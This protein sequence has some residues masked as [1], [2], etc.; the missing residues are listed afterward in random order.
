MLFKCVGP[1]GKVLG[2]NYCN[3]NHLSWSPTPTIDL[4]GI[5]PDLHYNIT[6]TKTVMIGSNTI[7]FTLPCEEC[8]LS[9]P[10]Y[11]FTFKEIDICVSYS[12]KLFAF[13]AAGKG[14]SASYN[15]IGDVQG[16]SGAFFKKIK[17]G[18]LAMG[19]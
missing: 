5:D 16:W 19:S 11:T 8:P 2:L 3:G 12:L 4:T 15:Y 6:I 18:D 7:T 17:F 1:P 14:E 13:N 10:E 9:T